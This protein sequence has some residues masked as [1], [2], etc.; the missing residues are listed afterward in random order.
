RLTRPTNTRPALP[1]Q[2]AQ[3]KPQPPPHISTPPF[4]TEQALPPAPIP[5]FYAGNHTILPALSHPGLKPL[6][7]ASHHAVDTVAHRAG[8][9][10][11][12]GCFDADALPAAAGCQSSIANPSLAW[13]TLL[14]A[15]TSPAHISDSDADSDGDLDE[16]DDEDD[17]GDLDA[18][19]M[20]PPVQVPSSPD[21]APRRRWAVS[22]SSPPR[23]PGLAVKETVLG[24]EG[25]D[26]GSQ[27]TR[28]QL[29]PGSLGMDS[30]LAV[31]PGWGDEEWDE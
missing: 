5:N 28:S 25:D 31:P 26:L 13:K 30:L 20:Q 22:S 3:H 8:L 19:P 2:T 29:L 18:V 12:H 17:D 9:V 6:P 1:S 24:E 15:N 27:W 16:D 14:I 23:R 4:L 7:P 10:G 21:T 11:V